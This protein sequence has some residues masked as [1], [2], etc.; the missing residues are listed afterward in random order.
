MTLPGARADAAA[1]KLSQAVALHQRGELERA[2]V[3][4]MEIIRADASNFDALHLLGVY[5]LQIGD[6]PTA[7][8]FVSRAL[9][10]NPDSAQALMHFSAI[11]QRQGQPKP[12]LAAIER[13]LEVDPD[14]ATALSN[15]AALLSSQLKRSAEAM[16]LLEKALLLAPDDAE[17]W[18]NMGYALIDLRRYDEALPCLEESLRLK[19]GNALA[20][21]NQGNALQLLNRT[22]EAMRSYDAALAIAPD[23]VDARF[24]QSTCRLLD[25]DLEGGFAQYESRRLKP[26]YR[27]AAA[28]YAQPVWLGDAPLRGKTLLAHREQ[29]LGDTLQMCR[30]AP[31]LAAQG[32]RVILRVQA[33]LQPL[34]ANIEGVHA[35]IDEDTPL[36]SFDL[37]IPLLSLPLALSTGIDSVPAAVPYLQADAGRAAAWQTRLG[38]AG[39]RR[40][41]LAWAGNP[42]HENDAAR[43]IPLTRFQRLLIPGIEFIAL[44][45][46]LRAAERLLLQG[47]PALRSYAGQQTDFAETAALVAQLDLVVC[48][49]TAIAHL[50]GA[51]GKPVWLL[52]PFAP[53]WRWMLEREDSPWYPSM[54]LFRQRREDDWDEVLDRVIEALGRFAG[55]PN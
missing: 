43:S 38:P 9:Q 4:Y 12:A 13:A 32:A 15:C 40:I 47:L 46:D 51:M 2:A 33:S 17:A 29:G 45:R 16:P 19:P 20:L 54:R 49:D 25:G 14:S 5:A 24:G 52:L 21:Y 34:L 1:N 6:L 11:L 8:S 7:H 42:R 48:V 3:L 23:L 30:Y 44:Q 55:P 28:T 31:L 50:A 39:G 37:H 35:V 41:G 53:D 10:V 36:P 18:N 26:A 22:A 27:N